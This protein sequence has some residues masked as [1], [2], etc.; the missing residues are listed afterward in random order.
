MIKQMIR[1][2]F[3]LNLFFLMGCDQSAKSNVANNSSVLRKGNGP[4]PQTLD[5]HKAEG[6]PASNI[7]RDL[8]EGLISEAADG[9]LIP[10]VAERWEI[11]A[12]G[13]IYTL[14]LRKTARWSNG[15][16]LTAQDF[17]YSL[18]RSIDPLT[19]SSYSQ[20][21][22]C[23][24][25]VEAIIAGK[26]AVETLGVR[27]LDEH[28]LQ[29]ALKAATPYFLG[30]LTH[31]T[32]YPVHRATVEAWQGHFSRP[33]RLV[34]N[35]A[36]NLADWV[37]QS[38]I[39]LKKNPQYWNAQRTQIDRVI[40]YAID[41]T[42]QELQR[43]WAD[44]IDWTESIPVGQVDWVREKF[45]DQL[46]ISP[47]LGTYYFGLNVT[48]SPF[49]DQ[50]TLRR[51][52]WLAIDRDIIVKKIT[53]AGELPAY[54]WVPPGVMHYQAQPTVDINW[55][56]QQ[57]QTKARQL[58][59][60]AGYSVEN[61]LKLELLYNTSENHKRIALAVAAMWKD[62]LGVETKL[63]NEEWKVFL[64]HRKQLD[65]T[66]VIRGGWIAD[67]NDAWSF[68][69]LLQSNN[70]M[71][72]TG[73]SNANYDALLSRASIESDLEKR[74]QLLQQAERVLLHDVPIIPLFFYVSKSLI[75]PTVEGFEGNVMDH[76]YSKHLSLKQ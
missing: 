23:I 14:Y 59:Q 13:T 63:I 76:H 28:T 21:L 52:L 54:S 19:G 27:A 70:A 38:H 2:L 3:L 30:L 43:F 72:N 29:I 20:V 34:S 64:D 26:S 10:G 71:N 12:D 60:Q 16:P 1:L 17:V 68:A 22:S 46:H 6:V 67:Y 41:D 44:E 66:Q 15:E 18:R 9:Q 69:E 49:K 42:S 5:P 11:S 73:Y 75:K 61:P 50:P 35:G 62:A 65:Q 51:A 31:S 33:D 7:L 39:T 45:G 74:Q 37:V 53:A 58:Y 47:Y 57:R 24:V 32:T 56:V 4:E 48:R 25:N 8:Y 36:Y 55:S 40:Y